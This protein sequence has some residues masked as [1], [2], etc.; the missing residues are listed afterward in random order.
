MVLCNMWSRGLVG[1]WTTIHMLPTWRWSKVLEST[2]SHLCDRQHI[3]FLWS[4][5]FIVDQSLLTRIDHS[6]HGHRTHQN[7]PLG[8]LPKGRSPI[9]NHTMEQPPLPIQRNIWSSARLREQ[10]SRSCEHYRRSMPPNGLSIQLQLRT[11]L[12]Q[13]S[14]ST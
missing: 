12:I 7:V 14:S 13:W 5:V 1:K 8:H 3:V 10:E 9:P 6:S 11:Q 2:S 4:R